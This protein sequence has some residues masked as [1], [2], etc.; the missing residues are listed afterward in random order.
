MN[1]GTPR[2]PFCSLSKL[3]TLH[4]RNFRNSHSIMVSNVLKV[5]DHALGGVGG[6]QGGLE[7]LTSRYRSACW[8]PL[9]LNQSSHC[10]WNLSSRTQRTVLST[11]LRPASHS[12]PFFM[13]CSTSFR[14]RSNDFDPH[15]AWWLKRP[16]KATKTSSN[17]KIDARNE[18]SASKH[19]YV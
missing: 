14:Q 6:G 13:W 7:P 17:D 11:C 5:G 16:P 10:P 15:S 8:R 12:T 9:R 19:A 18:L 3:N 2:L 4:V 1:W